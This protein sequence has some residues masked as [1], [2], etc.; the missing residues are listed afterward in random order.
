V[1]QL[2]GGLSWNPWLNGVTAK[3]A[4]WIGEAGGVYH[5][6]V[7]AWD[8]VSNASNDG[9]W[10]VFGPVVVATVTKYYWH[11]GQ[12]V[13]MR[14]GD[15]VYYLSG[16]HLGSTSLTTD[17]NGAVVSEVRYHPY[18]QERWASGAMPTDFGFTS[19]RREGFGLYDYNARYYSPYLN[20]FISPD[21]L[22]PEPGSSQSWNRYAYVSNNPLKYVDPSGHCLPEQCPWSLTYEIVDHHASSRG[23]VRYRNVARVLAALT[24]D[25]TLIEIP[26]SAQDM[27][28][29][30]AGFNREMARELRKE[31]LL[32]Y[33]P[34]V[35]N[36]VLEAA[37]MAGVLIGGGNKNNNY[38]PPNNGDT[39]HNIKGTEVK[40]P[41][42]KS[43]NDKTFGYLIPD[44][45][46]WFPIESGKFGHAM[47]IPK[48]TPGFNGLTRTHVEGHA[49]AYMGKHNIRGASLLINNNPCPGG[50]GCNN[51]LKYML[52][53]GARLR[54][55]NPHTGFRQ[56]YVG[57]PD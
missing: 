53:E 10:E 19:Q 7:R 5:F 21:T 45:G 4:R 46:D 24:V 30:K 29:V 55:Y 54:V 50:S 23:M 32:E 1:G 47:D 35:W 3:S 28:N 43:K 9:A 34:E 16:D 37:A 49:A 13:A 52:P 25:S 12:R 40:L 2:Y 36:E 48:G 14:R 42:R 8:N 38:G 57:V 6:R 18:G 56:A 44:K 26:L 39:F 51:N 33:D 31:G 11:G 27:A 17:A 15:V 22:V 41:V 20:R